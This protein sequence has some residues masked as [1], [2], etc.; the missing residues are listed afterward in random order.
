M[1]ICQIL[2][3]PQKKNLTVSKL[4]TEKNKTAPYGCASLV[5]DF[6]L[7]RFIFET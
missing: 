2:L 7:T 6:K 5:L 1:P 3:F 4:Q